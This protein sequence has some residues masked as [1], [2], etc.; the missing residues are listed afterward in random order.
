MVLKFFKIHEERT[1]ITRYDLSKIHI[2][3]HGGSTR[4]INSRTID[5]AGRYG[6]IHINTN[7]DYI[8]LDV[9]NMEW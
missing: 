1:L 5:E 7:L 9:R 3:T 2:V 6:I 8:E 4:T